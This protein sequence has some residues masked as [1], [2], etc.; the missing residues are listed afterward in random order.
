MTTRTI[1]PD[2]LPR[3]WRTFGDR[4]GS[5]RGGP[6][7]ESAPTLADAAVLAGWSIHPAQRAFLVDLDS[8]LRERPAA[9]VALVVGAHPTP[10]GQILAA[11]HPGAQVQTFDIGVSRP[12]LHMKLAVGGPFDII[13][14]DTR[15]GDQH[16][17]L[18]RDTFFHLRAGG[19]FVVRDYRSERDA[20]R[21]HAPRGDL[22]PFVGELLRDRHHEGARVFGARRDQA[23]LGKSIGEIT[24]GRRHLV[25][26]SRVSAFSKMR[27]D[28]LNSVLETDR[29][30][31]G[32]VVAT[33][34]GQT[35]R[36]RGVRLTGS[37]RS[38]HR[39]PDTFTVPTLSLR[40]YTDVVC[41][42]GQVVVKDSLLLPDSFRHNQ[43][44]R[45]T[46]RWTIDLAPGFAQDPRVADATDHLDG[47]YFYLDLEWRGHFGHVM[48]EQLSRMWAWPQAKRDHP[49]LKALM[50]IATDSPGVASWQVELL[51]AAGVHADDIVTFVDPVRVETLVAATPMFS[52]PSYVHP[53]IEN[54]WSDVGRT[55]AA[56]AP[57][58]EYPARIFVSRRPT[59]IRP[60]HNVTDVEELFAAHGFA[61]LYPEDLALSEQA[62]TFR[63]AEVIAGFAGSGMFS[64]AYCETSK[65]VIT[66]APESYT[67]S[68]EHLIG[69]VRGH[70]IDEIWSTPDVVHPPGGWSYEAFYGGFTFD[71]DDEGVVLEQVLADLDR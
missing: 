34:P 17:R 30:D 45:L 35:F 14:D 69:A 6:E 8:L 22:M 55:L 50:S 33:I 39:R 7:R 63:R 70:R 19:A 59:P 27:E 64:L 24:L 10:I 16:V 38:D 3:R 25:L 26:R 23:M 48:T 54:L 71:F 60:C 29:P 43:F 44:P 66:I 52:L 65:R 36:S 47:A 41:C 61:V 46:N 12:A 62:E 28:E 4:A 1:G 32:R 9:R 40:E 21:S 57:A 5:N 49:E 13:L 20:R 31:S 42:E 11:A 67:S 53:S 15:H 2:S 68:N 18:L 51:G 56:G 58:G 37:E